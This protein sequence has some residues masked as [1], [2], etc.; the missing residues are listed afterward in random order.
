KTRPR[1]SND[2]LS[3]SMTHAITL[4]DLPKG[5]ER[6]DLA[7]VS[8]LNGA[9]LV[10][11]IG[12][13]LVS[14]CY[15]LGLFNVKDEAGHVVVNRQAEFA[16]SWLFAFFFFFTITNGGIFW[17]MLQHI[18]NAGWS[19]AVR[20]FFENLGANVS[21]MFFLA[22]PFLCV[23]SIQNALWEWMAIH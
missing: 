11:G 6:L 18:T 7:K 4:D 1:Q 10:L 8:K 5:G 14:V 16:Y 12:G 13:L 19:V 21:W 15:M 23:P 22:L 2:S 20:R 3:S 17:V 9:L